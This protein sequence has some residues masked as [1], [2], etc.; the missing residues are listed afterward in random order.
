MHVSIDTSRHNASHMHDPRGR[1]GWMFEN[2]A[3]E[4]VF[5]FSGTYGEAR[6]AA[7]AW[8]KA[9]GVPVLYVCS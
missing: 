8:A 2:E 5:T 9:N 4:H 1:G 7:K 6:R 3:G